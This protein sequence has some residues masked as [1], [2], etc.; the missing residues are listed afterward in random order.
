[1]KKTTDEMLEQFT[2]EICNKHGVKSLVDPSLN[3]IDI[4]CVFNEMVKNTH[5]K[6]NT[7]LT[8]S[9]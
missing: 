2:K 5:L 4:I 8:G 7:N 6:K 9:N 3:A 1:M